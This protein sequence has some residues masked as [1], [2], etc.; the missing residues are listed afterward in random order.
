[1]G[2]RSDRNKIKH[3]AD[4]SLDALKQAHLAMMESTRINNDFIRL[5]LKK[6]QRNANIIALW[7]DD[8]SDYI[9]DNLPAIITYMDLIIKTFEQ[10]EEGL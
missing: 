7:A 2:R 1:M 5:K 6:A 4:A 9:N 3:N 8:R 10:F